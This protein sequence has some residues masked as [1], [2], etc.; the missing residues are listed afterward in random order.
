MCNPVGLE[1]TRFWIDMF[2]DLLG[3]CF[4]HVIT[5]I[6][7]LD[8]GLFPKKEVTVG[9]KSEIIVAYRKLHNAQYECFP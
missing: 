2:K 9:E 3:H 8:V 5:I 1:N 6:K 4:I 7:Q